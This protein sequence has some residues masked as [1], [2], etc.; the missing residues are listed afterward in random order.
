MTELAPT[1]PGVV[2]EAPAKVNLHLGVGVLRADGYHSVE[3]V[4]QTVTLTDTLRMRRAASLTLRSVPDIGVP[5]ELNLAWKAAERMAERFGRAPDVE[6]ELRKA[7]PSSAGLGGGS[8]DAAAVLAGLAALWQLELSDPD[9][10]Q[11]VHEVAARLGADVPFFLVGGTALFS[12]RGDMLVRRIRAPQLH[13]VFV[14]P[15]APVATASAYAAFDAAPV[16]AAS[17]EVLV[18]ACERGDA[19]RVARALSNNLGVIAGRLV[20]EV[21]DAL[22]WVSVAEGVLGAAVCG[23]GSAVFGVCADAASARIAAEAAGARGWWSLAAESRSS[24]VTVR[25]DEEVW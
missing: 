17:S 1:G 2:V 7:I 15:S 21:A 13:I 5:D 9:V 11:A 19:V 22:A 3:T 25:L 10:R 20:P 16:P 18:E 14:K 12:G 4:L 6:I 23:S 24:G 8:S